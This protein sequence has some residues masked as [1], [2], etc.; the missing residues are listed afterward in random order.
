MRVVQRPNIGFER[1][2]EFGRGVF[3]ERDGSKCRGGRLLMHAIA[4]ALMMIGLHWCTL[5]RCGMGL[6]RFSTETESVRSTLPRF[7]RTRGRCR[8]RC[9]ARCWFDRNGR[10]HG[11]PLPCLIRRARCRA[12]FQ[13]GSSPSISLPHR[14]ASRRKR[15][16]C[17]SP[18]ASIRHAF[19]LKPRSVGRIPH[20]ARLVAD[21]GEHA[22]L[23]NRR[24]W[25]QA[26]TCSS[27]WWSGR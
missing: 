14:R 16:W 20:P 5:S 10:L 25:S 19:S 6:G 2:F 17:Y 13:V 12:W 1:L 4:E 3:G 24:A 11:A 18:L 9:T 8:L 15:R 26:A 7:C 23:G 27:R 22:E 21:G